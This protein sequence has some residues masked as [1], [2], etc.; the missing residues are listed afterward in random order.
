[1]LN[2]VLTFIN[3]IRANLNFGRIVQIES[4]GNTV[5]NSLEL[6]L[7]GKLN[8]GFTF[9]ANYKI[10]K[11]LSDFEDIFSLPINSFET[12]QEWGAA[13]LDQRHRFNTRLMFPSWKSFSFNA[14][15]RLE[16]PRPYTITTGRDDNGDSVINDRPFGISRN[17]ERGEWFKQVDA[18]LSWRTKLGKEEANNPLSKIKNQMIFTLNVQNI[19]NQ[20]NQQNFIG[21]QTSPFF[22]QAISAAQPRLI[23][24]GMNWMF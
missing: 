23:Q 3:G 24:F 19:F 18:S 20:T 12:S 8:K 16:S 6:K 14:T 9:D 7:E 13:N 4:S 5:E 15:F 10:G 17:S 11:V 21:I 1:M 2:K 22:R